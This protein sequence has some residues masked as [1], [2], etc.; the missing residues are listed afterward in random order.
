MLNGGEAVPVDVQHLRL[1]QSGCSDSRTR[2]QVQLAQ[3]QKHS[4]GFE[5]AR[6]LLDWLL[7]EMHRTETLSQNTPDQFQRPM[8]VCWWKIA[9]GLR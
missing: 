8:L 1:M 3:R 2:I 4:I 9:R 6:S 5:Y 7:R